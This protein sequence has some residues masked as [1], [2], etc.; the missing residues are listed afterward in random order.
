MKSP[1]QPP[2]TYWPK[3]FRWVQDRNPGD[4]FIPG[5]ILPKERHLPDAGRESDFNI[6]VI[7]E[8]I[9]PSFKDPEPWN[10]DPAKECTEID[11]PLVR[12]F[13]IP[14]RQGNYFHRGSPMTEQSMFGTSDPPPEVWTAYEKLQD[15]DNKVDKDL[16]IPFAY[17]HFGYPDDR[18]DEAIEV[19]GWTKF[20]RAFRREYWRV[21]R[22]TTQPTNVTGKS[23]LRPFILRR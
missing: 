23:G 21:F 14:H 8:Y 19:R 16:V 22:A 9:F 15:S 12:V 13:K 20:T 4:P 6:S 11:C 10:P 2:D 18:F 1:D 5:T 3:D 17:Y 7:S